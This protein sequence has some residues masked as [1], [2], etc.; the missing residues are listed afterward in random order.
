MPV[1]N[2]LLC[3]LVVLLCA[4]TPLSGRA[5]ALLTGLTLRW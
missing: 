1:S 5:R 4:L 3:V 2:F